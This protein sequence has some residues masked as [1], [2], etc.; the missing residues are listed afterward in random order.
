MKYKIY[1]LLLFVGLV[2]YTGCVFS[3]KPNVKLEA[4]TAEYTPEKVV[5]AEVPESPELTPEEKVEVQEE[6]KQSY[7]EIEETLDVK[8]KS[9]EQ[10]RDDVHKILDEIIEED[11]SVVISF[12]MQIKNPLVYET[13][14]N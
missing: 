11:S 8:K 3:N 1:L 13:K 2:F 14:E 7:K 5:E 4:T 9:V 10:M 12:N 6:I